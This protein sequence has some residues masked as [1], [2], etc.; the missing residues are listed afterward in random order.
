MYDT[1]FRIDILTN[2]RSSAITMAQSNTSSERLDRAS[3]GTIAHPMFY[4]ALE[5]LLWIR[6]RFVL[7]TNVLK[8]AYTSLTAA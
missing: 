2:C 1:S 6:Y 8:P 7:L 3:S 4:L 5:R